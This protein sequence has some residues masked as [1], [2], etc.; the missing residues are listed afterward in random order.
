MLIHSI[1]SSVILSMDCLQT[2]LLTGDTY[3]LEL[4]PKKRV[5]INVSKRNLIGGDDL[6]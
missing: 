6:A 2:L 1:H 4:S 5:H 3:T